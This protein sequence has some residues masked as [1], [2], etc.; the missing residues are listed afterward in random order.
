MP[1]MRHSGSQRRN[2]VIGYERGSTRARDLGFEQLEDYLAARRAERAS[3]HRIRT[4]LNCRGSVAVRL[5]T[6]A[7]LS[8][9][10]SRWRARL[11]D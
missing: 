2:P 5:L 1:L 6:Q 3:A 9:S 11:R 10:G 4:E 7:P 8:L